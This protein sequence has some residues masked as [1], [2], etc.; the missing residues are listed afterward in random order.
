MISLR[1]IAKEIGAKRIRLYLAILSVAWGTASIAF[2]LSIGEGLRLAFMNKIGGGGT[3]TLA[4][5]PSVTSL[6]Y[7][8]TP[9]GT[10]ISLFYL[11]HD[12]LDNIPGIDLVAPVKQFNATVMTSAKHAFASPVA[13]VPAYKNI[14]M[15]QTVAP[16]RFIDRVDMNQQKRVAYLGSEVAKTLFPRMHNPIGMTIRLG[17][18]VFRVIGVSSSA[19]SFNQYGGTVA[20]QVIIPLSTYQGL[21]GNQTVN[22]FVFQLHNT[23]DLDMVKRELTDY[24]AKSS[25]FSPGD[26]SALVFNDSAKTANTLNK[27]LYGFQAFL[28]MIGGIT[29]FISGV[30]IANIM[31]ISIKGATRIIGTQMAIGA[32]SMNILMHYF[33]EAMFITLIG[34]L[35]G[36]MLTLMINGLFDVMPIHAQFYVQMGS[37]KPTLSWGVLVVVIA[38]LGFIGF[39]SAIFPARNAASISPA[40]ALREE[41]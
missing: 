16:G 41:G 35:V 11:N 32:T 19:M 18:E 2:M 28:G 21:T 8:G 5:Q 25:G 23:A 4:V 15:I 12:D 3:T 34:G 10:P 14:S 9:K 39:L 37:P 29:L 13:T 30:G 38:V 1:V 24:F 33:L 20:N 6:N 17:G 7:K 26:D 22:Q 36:I 31:Y 40:I 27:F